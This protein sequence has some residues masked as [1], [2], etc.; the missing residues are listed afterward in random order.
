[1]TLSFLHLKLS[2][3]SFAPQWATGQFGIVPSL[4]GMVI[5]AVITVRCTRLMIECHITVSPSPL[6][7]NPCVTYPHPYP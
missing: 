4:V 1:M 7:L 2:L 3:P 5:I 6:P